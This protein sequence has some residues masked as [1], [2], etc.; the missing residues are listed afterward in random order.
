MRKHFY[1]ATIPMVDYQ[2]LFVVSEL[3]RFMKP[4]KV[5]EYVSEDNFETIAVTF[6][7][8]IRNKNPGRGFF[9]M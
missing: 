2:H 3:K 5:H 9:C 4:S 7:E 1:G 6:L 8:S